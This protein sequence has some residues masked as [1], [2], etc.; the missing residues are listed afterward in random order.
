MEHEQRRWISN[1]LMFWESHEWDQAYS[2]CAQTDPAFERLSGT[3][4]VT[5]MIGWLMN[6]YPV[7]LE[8]LEARK[9]KV[10]V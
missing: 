2:A 7:S 6:Q 1:Q 10:R 4:Q 5:C 3:E 8:Q 9:R